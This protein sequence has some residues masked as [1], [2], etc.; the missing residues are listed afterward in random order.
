MKALIS[1]ED[2]L[3]DYH[4][5]A[6]RTQE[7]YRYV[8]GLGLA[9]NHVQ[10]LFKDKKQGYLIVEVKNSSDINRITEK[11]TPNPM[12]FVIDNEDNVYVGSTNIGTIKIIDKALV[13]SDEYIFRPVFVHIV[14][15]NREVYYGINWKKSN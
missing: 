15:N 10:R 2:I 3:A 14:E 9:V 13:K 12:F 1:V 8:V 5:N 11:C 4:L 6:I 7:L